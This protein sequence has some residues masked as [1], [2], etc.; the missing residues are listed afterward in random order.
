MEILFKN[1]T[2]YGTENYQEFLQFH[3]KMFGL[4]YD[5]LSIVTILLL[6]FFTIV[7]I[8]LR[9]FLFIM[10]ILCGILCFFIWRYIYPA[11]KV[12]KTY[13]GET[14]QSDTKSIFTFT[15]YKKYFTIYD[16]NNTSEIKYYKL[17]K[18]FETPTFFYL[19]IDHSRSLLLDKKNFS[20]GTSDDFSKF[21]RKKCW[22]KFQNSKMS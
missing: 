13:N 10:V 14:V 9:H 19:Y 7:Q 8:Y 4:K 22:N 17:Y 6:L 21:I 11:I 3:S 20:I 12:S 16:N 5:L 1:T 15:F 2:K 18:V